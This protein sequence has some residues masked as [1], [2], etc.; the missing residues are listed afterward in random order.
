MTRIVSQTKFCIGDDTQCFLIHITNDTITYF[1]ILHFYYINNGAIN[2]LCCD[3]SQK[4]K[5]HLDRAGISS[6]KAAIFVLCLCYSSKIIN[7]FFV[8]QEPINK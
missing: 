3:V 2:S 5:L 7:F 6:N 8:L 4:A 1:T